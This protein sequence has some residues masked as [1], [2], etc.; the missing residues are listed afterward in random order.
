M[1]KTLSSIFCVYFIDIVGMGGSSRP[2]NYLRFKFSPQD[3]IDYFVSYIEKWRIEIGDLK[4]FIL[5]GHSFGG[6]IAG[7]YTVKYP[8]H[9]KKLLMLSPIGVRVPSEKETWEGRFHERSQKNGP[10]FWIGPT[11]GK[12]WE[13][14]VSPF[15]FGRVIG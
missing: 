11:M 10:P 6:Y 12:I 14:K 13:H 9:V 5:A 8:Q 4:D 1:M 15:S 2:D 7:N 3:S